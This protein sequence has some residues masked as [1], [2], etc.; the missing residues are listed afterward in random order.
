MDGTI[1]QAQNPATKLL[2]AFS[3]RNFHVKT[4]RSSNAVGIGFTHF[5]LDPS[6]HIEPEQAAQA[7][8]I[9]NHMPVAL[10]PAGLPENTK[11][12]SHLDKQDYLD[13]ANSGLCNT[14]LRAGMKSNGHIELT[15]E[16]NHPAFPKERVNKAYEDFAA[17]RA[18]RLRIEQVTSDAAITR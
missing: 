9:L 17:T 10:P 16:G 4:S 2:H 5:T 6:G 8:K 13:F 3:H 1:K 18:G 14:P 7:V 11:G 12:W 15:L